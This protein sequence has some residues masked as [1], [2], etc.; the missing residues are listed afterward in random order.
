MK[1]KDY[2]QQIEDEEQMKYLKKWSEEH[3][4]KN[5]KKGKKNDSRR[6]NF[7]VR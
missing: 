4:I 6:Q 3:K 7:N 2:L 5:E 1:R